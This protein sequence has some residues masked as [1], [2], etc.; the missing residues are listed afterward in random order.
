MKASTK[1]STLIVLS[2]LYL[3]LSSLPSTFA[4]SISVLYSTERKAGKEVTETVLLTASCSFS[5]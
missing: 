2:S 4:T 5:P 1:L 3:A